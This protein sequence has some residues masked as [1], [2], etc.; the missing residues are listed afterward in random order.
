M[1]L[2]RADD[3]PWFCHGI[4]CPA[5]TFSNS[6]ASSLEVRNYQ[7]NLWS[8]TD[9][10]GTSLDDAMDEGFD[11]LF[12]YISGANE[13]QVKIPM[14]APVLVKVLPGAGPNCESTF[15]VSFFVPFDYQTSAGPPSPSD[16]TVYTQ[17]IDA[18]NVAVSEFGGFAKS[19]EII[20]KA[21]QLSSEVEASA[22]VKEDTGSLSEGSW[23]FAG[24]DPPFRVSNRHNEV[25]IKLEK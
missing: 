14:T 12:Q 17:R 21:A 7:S 20:A 3:S 22:D 24:Y 19:K 13:G 10:K 6:T 23:F 5:F 9:I 1:S 11:K 2:A 15:T 4:D 25:W 18:M 16:P 8:S